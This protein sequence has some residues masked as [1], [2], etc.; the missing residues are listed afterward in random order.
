MFIMYMY[1]SPCQEC[2][3]T[4]TDIYIDDYNVPVWIIACIHIISLLPVQYC[5]CTCV[6]SI[7]TFSIINNFHTTKMYCSIEITIK[8]K[9]SKMVGCVYYLNDLQF[10]DKHLVHI[11]H[12]LK[13][14]YY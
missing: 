10:V 2:K 3:H 13:N 4:H 7:E 11:A 9:T 6:Y 14:I 1:I 5:Y 8:T 12:Y